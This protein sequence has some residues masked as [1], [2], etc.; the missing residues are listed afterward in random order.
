M[1]D[2]RNKG[3]LVKE[4]LEVLVNLNLIKVLNLIQA[5]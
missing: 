3:E 5:G 2:L 1:D 4:G